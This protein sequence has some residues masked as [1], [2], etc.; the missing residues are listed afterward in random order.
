MLQHDEPIDFVLAT[1]V[2]HT[3]RHF[4]SLA[5]KY[6]G[7]EMKWQGEGINDKGID[8]STGKTLIEI[9]ARYFRPAEVELLVGDASLA[10]E[11]LGW[12]STIQLEELVGEMMESDIKLI[13][14]DQYLIDGGHRV[15]KYFE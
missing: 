13:Q 7:I 3:V 9:D 10:K 5:F 14:R 12:E 2:N 8:A 11:K 6:V 4:V 15:M 1:G